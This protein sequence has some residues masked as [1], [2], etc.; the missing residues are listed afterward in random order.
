MRHLVWTA[1]CVYCLAGGV[2]QRPHSAPTCT[3]AVDMAVQ[4]RIASVGDGQLVQATF[5]QHRPHVGA[6]KVRAL[7]RQTIFVLDTPPP[8]P[9]PAVWSSKLLLRPCLGCERAL[10]HAGRLSRASAASASR[11]TTGDR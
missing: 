3:F 1:H 4:F 2:A 11:A 5:G 6:G 7:P 9:P 10:L 8:P